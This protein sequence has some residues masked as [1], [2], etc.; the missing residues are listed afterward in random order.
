MR[1]VVIPGF[2]Q[3]PQVVELP[4]PEPG[5]GDVLVRV[6][7]AGMNP[8]DWKVADGALEGVVEHRFPVVMGSDG[9]GV[10]EAVGADVTRFRPGDRVYGQFMKVALG[11]GSYAEHTVAPAEGKLALV[12]E[13]LPF[14]VAAALPTASVTAYQAIEAADLGPDRTI[15]VNGAS[16]GVGQAAVQLAA[17]RGARVLATAPPDLADLLRDLGADEVVDFTSG[18][19]ADQVR[20][21]H[22]DG[23]DAVLDLVSTAGQAE[24]LVALLRPGGV[25][26]STNGALD[27]DALAEQ[28][29]RGV[30]L[31]SNVTPEVLADIAELAASGRLRVTIDAE[32]A[33]SD[34]PDAIARARAGH[35]RGKTV[36][37]PDLPAEQR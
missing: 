32:V 20:A 33:L 35:A 28:H 37:V 13:G 5:P 7:A 12:P 30:N 2:H 4:V 15:L 10:V 25:I 17:A 23:I 19:T 16:G 21:A 9:A 26:V 1:A 36:I 6:H 3:A 31:F 34:A 27:P 8:F 14:T 29:L 22:P 18:P 11:V 24:S